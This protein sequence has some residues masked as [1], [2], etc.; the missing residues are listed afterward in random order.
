MTEQPAGGETAPQQIFQIDLGNDRYMDMRY[1]F[2]FEHSFTQSENPLMDSL[3]VTFKGI[4]VD[5]ASG[6]EK[7]KIIY[8]GIDK[9]VGNLKFESDEARTLRERLIQESS[10]EHL[11]LGESSFTKKEMLD[12]ITKRLP[13]AE[14]IK[15]VRKLGIESILEHSNCA[16]RKADLKIPHNLKKILGINED[17]CHPEYLNRQIKALESDLARKDEFYKA[18]AKI[19]LGKVTEGDMG[20]IISEADRLTGLASGLDDFL[21]V[22]KQG[23]A[24]RTLTGGAKSIIDEIVKDTKASIIRNLTKGMGYEFKTGEKEGVRYDRFIVS[25]DFASQFIQERDILKRETEKKT[26]PI[27]KYNYL[28]WIDEILVQRMLKGIDGFRR[29]INESNN[30]LYEER[31]NIL[32]DAEDF[33][34]QKGKIIYGLRHKMYDASR[35]NKWFQKNKNKLPLKWYYSIFKSIE[36]RDKKIEGDA[37]KLDE[38]VICLEGTDEG[39]REC[40]DGEFKLHTDIFRKYQHIAQSLP[41]EVVDGFFSREKNQPF[42]EV[43]SEHKEKFKENLRYHVSRFEKIVAFH[44]ERKGFR[45]ESDEM[46]EDLRFYDTQKGRALGDDEVPKGPIDYLVGENGKK[47]LLLCED[48]SGRPV[49]DDEVPITVFS[50]VKEV[51]KIV[52]KE[53]KMGRKILYALGAA[54][55]VM[56]GVNVMQGYLSM[57]QYSAK[58]KDITVAEW[59]Q[60]TFQDL[61]GSFISLSKDKINL[62]DKLVEKEKVIEEKDNAIAQQDSTI[63]ELSE[64]IVNKNLGIEDNAT[65]AQIKKRL[66]ELLINYDKANKIIISDLYTY[67]NVRPSLDDVLNAYNITGDIRLLKDTAIYDGRM[68]FD[69]AHDTYIRLI[70]SGDFVKANGLN[71]AYGPIGITKN[72]KSGFLAT[73]G[74]EPSFWENIGANHNFSDIKGYEEYREWAEQYSPDFKINFPE[75]KKKVENRINDSIK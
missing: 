19:F 60:K 27:G 33:R 64:G 47:A 46:P 35:E 39:I 11:D 17:E 52:V 48:Y 75:R 67:K 20:H 30:M 36:A 70:N 32:A 7:E 57:K 55:A 53:R 25:K 26:N 4:E 2:D 56:F 14:T 41:D 51:P 23:I 28:K 24:A 69:K 29:E 16:T 62:S 58:Y 63:V 34:K 42:A 8:V 43:F 1:L 66:S 15:A 68:T 45:V 44:Q 12:D 40:E 74:S 38:R 37:A 73:Y 22:F 59:A 10:A 21:A 54:A 5:C 49:K 31:A 13:P 71:R 65:P 72:E 61:T 6:N 3:A 50:Q 9:N 18:L